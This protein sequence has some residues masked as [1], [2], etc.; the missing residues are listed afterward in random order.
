MI[1]AKIAWKLHE[2]INKKAETLYKSTVI[3]KYNLASPA[4]NI[5]AFE[6]SEVFDFW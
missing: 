5:K 4:S 3:E 1:Q 2:K 6:E